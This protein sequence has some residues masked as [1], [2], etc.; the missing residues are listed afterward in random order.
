MHLVF[1]QCFFLLFKKKHD[2]KNILRGRLLGIII[3]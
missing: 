1:F 2:K 3:L